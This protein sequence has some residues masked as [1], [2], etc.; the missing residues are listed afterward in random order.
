MPLRAT[1]P[2]LW[3][4]PKAAPLKVSSRPQLLAERSRNRL[5]AL[6]HA[7]GSNKKTRATAGN[8][9]ELSRSVNQ[10]L[11]RPIE[12][13]ISYQGCVVIGFGDEGAG[14]LAGAAGA[15]TGACAA[16]GCAA[17]ACVAGSCSRAK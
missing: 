9:L 8:Y 2:L 14:A 1:P 13:E 5:Q 3:N 15:G 16:G 10:R 4:F 11:F 6:A 7:V 17:G 12:Q